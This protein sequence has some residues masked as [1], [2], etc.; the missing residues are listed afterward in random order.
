MYLQP[1]LAYNTKNAV[2]ATF[3]SESTANWNADSGQ[4]WTIPIIAQMNKLSTLGPFPASYGFGA[5]YYLATPDGGPD[6]KL[7]AVFV[8]LLPKK[9]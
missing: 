3:S 2:T 6:W 7:R 1:F 8:L 9:K 5:G 4:T